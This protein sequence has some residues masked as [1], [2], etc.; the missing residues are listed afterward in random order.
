M[1]LSHPM[2]GVGKKKMEVALKPRSGSKAPALTIMPWCS[3][4]PHIEL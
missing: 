4:S 3:G 2:S 1:A